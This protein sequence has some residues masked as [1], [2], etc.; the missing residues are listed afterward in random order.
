[1]KDDARA[2]THRARAEAC[3]LALAGS[4]APDE[5]L[6]LSFLGAPAVRRVLGR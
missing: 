1:M 2:E 5:P 6:R 3:I 4:F